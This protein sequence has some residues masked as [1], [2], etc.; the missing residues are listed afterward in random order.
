MIGSSGKL[1]K[2]PS[3][4]LPL[5]AACTGD[6]IMPAGRSNKIGHTG[7]ISDSIC[8][9]LVGFLNVGDSP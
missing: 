3:R 6:E 7:A 2:N 1:V 5:A 9:F 8:V 4:F